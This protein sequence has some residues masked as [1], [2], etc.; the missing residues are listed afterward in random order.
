VTSS[1]DSICPRGETSVAVTVAGAVSVYAN[2]AVSPGA[3]WAGVALTF[4][5]ARAAPVPS[6][7]VA[8]RALGDAIVHE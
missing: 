4:C 7:P 3:T 2:D 1:V 5:T 6:V 8:E